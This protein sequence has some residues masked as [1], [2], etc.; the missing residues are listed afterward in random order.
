MPKAPVISH[1]EFGALHA[2]SP[3][4]ASVTRAFHPSIRIDHRGRIERRISPTAVAGS[5]VLQTLNREREV[6]FLRVSQAAGARPNR[7]EISAT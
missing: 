1:R 6:T 5:V 7:L 4:L 3:D 2:V